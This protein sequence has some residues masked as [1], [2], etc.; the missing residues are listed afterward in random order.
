MPRTLF[1]CWIRKTRGSLAGGSGGSGLKTKR[2]RFR[3]MMPSPKRRRLRGSLLRLGSGRL[4][5]WG[6]RAGHRT[7]WPENSKG[8][9]GDGRAARVRG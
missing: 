1:R 2:R 4:R 9:W 3:A 7:R 5:S 8:K 6:R